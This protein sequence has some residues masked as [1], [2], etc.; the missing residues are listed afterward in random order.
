V[1]WIKLFLYQVKPI[2]F[3]QKRVIFVDKAK[4]VTAFSLCGEDYLKLNKSYI[5]AIKKQSKK[6]YTNSYIVDSIIKD[7]QYKVKGWQI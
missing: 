6:F 1:V 3:L 2:V 7:S 4:G 5:T